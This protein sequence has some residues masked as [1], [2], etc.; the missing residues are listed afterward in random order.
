MRPK[1]AATSARSGQLAGEAGDRDRDQDRGANEI[2]C[3]HRPPPVEP[4]G[5]DT[6]VETEEECGHAVGEPDRNHS[7]RAAGLEREPHQRDVLERVSELADGDRDIDTAEVPPAQ[8]RGSSLWLWL[9]R[10]GH[11]ASLPGGRS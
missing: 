11:G 3:N 6:A 5:D 1:A 4:I 9:W 2:G 7:Q 8:E 10:H